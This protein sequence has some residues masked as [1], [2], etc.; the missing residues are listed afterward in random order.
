MEYSRNVP[1]FL[2]LRTIKKKEKQPKTDE[3]ILFN[4]ILEIQ[5]VIFVNSIPR[6][7]THF[8]EELSD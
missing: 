8:G 4:L 6:G 5:Q 1:F 2:S 7:Y 3:P